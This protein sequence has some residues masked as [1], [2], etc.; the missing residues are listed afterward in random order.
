MGAL[1]LIFIYMTILFRACLVSSKF[2]D[3]R[4]M[5][6]TMGLALM[7]TTQTFISMAVAVGLGPVTGQPLPMITMGGT[8]SL[9]TALYFGVMMAVS[10]EQNQIKNNLQSVQ[11][12][13]LNDIPDLE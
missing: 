6:I 5:L 1:G 8:S 2:G 10:R 12:E 9:A 3:V 13:S 7:L 11:E 4:A